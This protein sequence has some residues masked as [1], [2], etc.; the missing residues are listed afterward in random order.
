M[1][2]G[3]FFLDREKIV[4]ACFGLDV[5]SCLF[6]FLV[7]PV[8]TRVRISACL[9]GGVCIFGYDDDGRVSQV[10]ALN[11]CAASD[12]DEFLVVSLLS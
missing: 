7:L 3:F 5:S 6:V 12:G 1:V 2:C 9:S 11:C 4:Y 10:G 8:T